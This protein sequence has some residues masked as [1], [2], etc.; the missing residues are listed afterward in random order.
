MKKTAEDILALNNDDYQNRD[1]DYPSSGK[2]VSI[3]VHQLDETRF[4]VNASFKNTPESTARS[5]LE[6]YLERNEFRIKDRVTTSQT[7]D[8]HDDWV[9]AYAIVIL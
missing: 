8:Y 1:G 9:D 6:R 5:W 7:G 4:S 3:Y 2:P